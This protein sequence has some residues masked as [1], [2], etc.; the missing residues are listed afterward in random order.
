[1]KTIKEFKKDASHFI[2]DKYSL[3]VDYSPVIEEAVKTGIKYAQRWI[4]VEEEIPENV[5]FLIKN[6]I[7]SENVL[8]KRIWDDTGEIAIEVNCRFRPSERVGFVWDITYKNSRITEWRP[9]ERP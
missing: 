7:K 2:L 1:M 8:V 3:T 9:I 4:P 5:D 6:N